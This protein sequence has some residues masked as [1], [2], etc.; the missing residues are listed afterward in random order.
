MTSF[1]R[2][3]SDLIGHHLA[4]FVARYQPPPRPGYVELSVSY[5]TLTQGST[6]ATRFRVDARLSPVPTDADP[7]VDRHVVS[8]FIDGAHVEDVEIPIGPLDFSFPALYDAGQTGHAEFRY[9]SPAGVESRVPLVVEFPPFVL[10]D[11]DEPPPDEE[12]PA[13]PTPGPVELTAVPVDVPDE[14]P[15]AGGGPAGR[16]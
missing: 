1:L 7:P 4:A 13:P 15:D 2:D 5:Y 14:A 6:M 11:V 12:A 3:L 16:V 8:V 10:P 9:V